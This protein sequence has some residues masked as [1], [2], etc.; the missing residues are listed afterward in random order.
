MAPL[1]VGVGRREKINIYIHLAY[2]PW[3]SMQLIGLISSWFNTE[4]SFKDP[5]LV[6]SMS[7]ETNRQ[8]TYTWSA[9][10]IGWIRGT[11]IFNNSFSPCWETGSLKR[12]QRSYEVNAQRQ[13]IPPTCRPNHPLYEYMV[14]LQWTRR[15]N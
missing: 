12:D 2:N 14:S 13:Y 10:Y 1:G 5:K 8:Q 15:M 7:F 3:N 9:F 4:I 11:V 6:Y